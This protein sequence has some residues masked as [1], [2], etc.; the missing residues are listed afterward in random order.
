MNKK[1]VVCEVFLLTQPKHFRYTIS[2]KGMQ[3]SDA[4]KREILPEATKVTPESLS[5]FNLS[6]TDS[7]VSARSNA[8]LPYVKGA[9]DV[10]AQISYTYDDVDDYDEEDP[11][12][13]LEI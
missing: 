11:D 9:Q 3:C 8:T 4:R 12:Y 7:Q 1:R 5:T 6:L 13:D 10:I 2:E